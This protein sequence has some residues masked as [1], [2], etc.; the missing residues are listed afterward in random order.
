VLADRRTGRRGVRILRHQLHRVEER[1]Q[2]VDLRGTGGLLSDERGVALGLN[3][4]N[5]GD[6]AINF[7]SELRPCSLCGGG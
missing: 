6:S 3:L 7:S 1:D 2:R 4:G 5:Y